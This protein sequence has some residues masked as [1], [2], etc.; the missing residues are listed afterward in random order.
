MVLSVPL[1][2]FIFRNQFMYGMID[3][4]KPIIALVNGGAIG[5]GTTMLPHCDLVIAAENA[6]FY[7]PFPLIGIV[8]EFCSSYALPKIMGLAKVFIPKCYKLYFCQNKLRK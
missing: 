5:I 7:T 6:Y 8:P 1:M 4:K 3:C 2:I